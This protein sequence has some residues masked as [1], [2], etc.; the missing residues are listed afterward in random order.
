MSNY[1]NNNKLFNQIGL[2]T[3]QLNQKNH[4]SKIKM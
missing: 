3:K 1:K 4:N 2:P